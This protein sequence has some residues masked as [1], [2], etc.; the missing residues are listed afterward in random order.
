M[1]CVLYGRCFGQSIKR[2]RFFNSFS[3]GCPSFSYI[4]NRKN[5]AISAI[6]NNSAGVLPIPPLVKKYVG[7]PT[8]PPR[9]KQMSCRLVKLKATFVLTLVRSFGTGT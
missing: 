2:S 4:A 9:E 8:A 5:G 7:I 1:F 6:I 3:A